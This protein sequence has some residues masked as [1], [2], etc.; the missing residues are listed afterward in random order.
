MRHYHNKI[1]EASLN[2]LSLLLISRLLKQGEHI[3]LVSLNTR[4]VEWVYAEHIA[5]D[6]ARLLKEVE[7]RTDRG[8]VD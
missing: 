3:L 4:L 7:Q 5:T 8:L 1:L 2:S 6:T